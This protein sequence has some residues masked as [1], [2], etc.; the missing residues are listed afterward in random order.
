MH[1]GRCGNRG[2]GVGGGLG[3]LRNSFS[4]ADLCYC[5]EL[6]GTGRVMLRAAATEVGALL[7]EEIMRK[8]K[9]TLR[10]H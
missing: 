8:V 1:G 3:M 10:L 2:V 9:I 6:Y 5:T 7:T 4:Q